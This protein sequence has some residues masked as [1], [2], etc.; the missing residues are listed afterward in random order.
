MPTINRT[1]VDDVAAVMLR[2]S[3]EWVTKKFGRRKR[4]TLLEILG[5][6][7]VS[8]DDRILVACKLGVIP[9]RE[10]RLFACRTAARL[11]RAI[12]KSGETVP[13]SWWNAI[14]V[15]RRFANGKASKEELK[16][17]YWAASLAANC[18]VKYAAYYAPDWAAS[19]AAKHAAYS[20]A[21]SAA[22]YAADLA[23]YYANERRKQLADLRR[24]VKKLG[25]K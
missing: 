3:R 11:L 6:K 15:A 18:A 8:A 17:A 7:D 21:Y 22:Y 14:R 20:A 13:K 1:T 5:N 12:E 23:A 19:W 25:G 24:V 10:L 2:H 16:D 9:D 4:V